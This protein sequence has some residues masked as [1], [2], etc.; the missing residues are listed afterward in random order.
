DLQTVLRVSTQGNRTNPPGIRGLVF[1]ED[2]S[3]VIDYDPGNFV[4]STGFGDRQGGDCLIDCSPWSEVQLRPEMER[5]SAFWHTE[6]E[7]S[8]GLKGTFEASYGKR[9]SSISSISLGPSS[10]TPIRPDNFF[11]QNTTYYDRD[12]GTDV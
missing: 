5:W 12:L 2:G 10:G 7:F 3:R 11:L 4:Q 9:K 8:P 1:S 6:Y